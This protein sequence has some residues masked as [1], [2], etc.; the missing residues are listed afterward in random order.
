MKPD[1]SD[2]RDIF[3]PSRFSWPIHIIGLGGI[4]S[5]LILPLIKLG[6]DELHVWDRDVVEPHNI[7]AQLIYRS[8]DVG[9]PKV[10]AALSFVKHM[11][12]DCKVVSHNEFVEANTAL[13]GIV[14]SGVDSMASR[15]A[16]WQSVKWNVDVPLYLDGR[17]G[18][19]ALQLLSLNPCDFDM[20][21][22]YESWLFPDNEASDLPCAARTV[23][24]PPTVLAGL[25]AAQI[26]LHARGEAY[27]TNIQA[28]LKSSQF[29]SV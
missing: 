2:Q 18:G 20:V 24:H 23:I 13:E 11:E 15:Q 6:V 14:I 16:I 12:A 26:T 1:Y 7:P 22:A 5:A 4:G 28:H 19:E 3:D 9:A 27:R 8:S 21:T 17:I 10:Q 29:V 25:M